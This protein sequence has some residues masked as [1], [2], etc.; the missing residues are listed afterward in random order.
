MADI[1]SLC[2]SECFYQIFCCAVCCSAIKEETS[3]PPLRA[4]GPLDSN[5]KISS[6]S[7]VIL[8]QASKSLPRL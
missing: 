3:R 1:L 5:D 7:P 8:A 6:I 2:F 4:I